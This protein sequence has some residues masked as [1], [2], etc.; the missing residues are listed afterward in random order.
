MNPPGAVDRH[1]LV[2]VIGR[3]RPRERRDE[4]GFPAPWATRKQDRAPAHHHGSSAHE[5]VLRRLQRDVLR[6]R[7]TEA[8]ER[9][10]LI[11][12]GDALFA[13]GAHHEQSSPPAPESRTLIS[14]PR[15]AFA[16]ARW[17]DLANQWCQGVRMIVTTAP[18]P[19]A[20]N[21]I[22]EGPLV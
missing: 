9:R 3:A 19:S 7:D 17:Q 1:V 4:R 6:Q 5:Q 13:A 14:R 20:S 10:L 16:G 2:R 8:L 15:V 21:A 12:A 18:A 11:G 22:A